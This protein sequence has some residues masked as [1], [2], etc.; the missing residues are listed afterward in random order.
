M[1]ITIMIIIITKIM[2]TKIMITKI[3]VVEV[4]LGYSSNSTR[5]WVPH[6]RQVT[7]HYTLFTC[8]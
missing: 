5:K 8:A 2:I 6:A 4:V 3:I 1:M 7:Y